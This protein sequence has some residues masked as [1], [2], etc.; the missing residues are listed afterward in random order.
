[1]AVKKEPRRVRVS[2]PPECGG[3]ALGAWI[4]VSAHRWQPRRLA[5]IFSKHAGGLNV[6]VACVLGVM[7][8]FLML[9]R[10]AIDNRRGESKPC[11][12]NVPILYA[13]LSITTIHNVR[14]TVGMRCLPRVS[15]DDQ[16]RV[17]MREIGLETVEC[18][19]S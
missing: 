2:A 4:R 16:W 11:T 19:H 15:Y 14:L 13:D 8:G 3:K 9:R 17:E 7:N 10:R 6:A 1:M 18:M 5:F 12:G